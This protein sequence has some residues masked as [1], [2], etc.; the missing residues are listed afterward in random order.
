VLAAPIAR[1]DTSSGQLVEK[2]IQLRREHRDAEALEQFKRADQMNPTPRI[3]AQIGFAEQAL[4]QW[5]D[6]E[7][8]LNLALSASDDPWI[9][10]HA[11]ALK[12]ALAA[13]EQHLASLTIETNVDGAE[14]WLNGARAAMAP[15][16]VVAGTV[17]VEVRAP[18]YETVRR[19]IE[20]TA[21]QAS[22]ER[23]ELV[24]EP[25]KQT[26]VT[27]IDAP[28]VVAEPSPQRFFAWGALAASGVVLAG[29]TAAQLVHEQAARHY[30]DNSLCGETQ[31]ASRDERCGT[32][33]GRAETAQTFATLGY[34]A[35]GALGLASA[36]LFWTAPRHGGT[37]KVAVSIDAVPAG[38]SFAV[39]GSF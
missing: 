4:G 2:G 15:A 22:S 34:V 18:G 36:V 37:K 26:P 17:D 9:V 5:L 11:P 13:I 25:Q 7:K 6:A 39:Q 16:R 30:D 1:A 10:E 21:G 38:A 12:Q 31:T 35:G 8:D 14:L 32:Y 27:S 23:I 20:I 33:K 3:R 29:A 24:A 28:P 19:S